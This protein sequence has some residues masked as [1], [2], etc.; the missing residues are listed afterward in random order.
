MKIPWIALLSL[1]L[2]GM[3]LAEGRTHLFLLS[4]Q[5]NMKNM[6]YT[7][8]FLPLV[9][10]AFPRDEVVIVKVAVGGVPISRW[11]P[12]AQGRLYQQLIAQTKEKLSGKKPDSITFIWMQGE[13]DHQ[14]DDTCQAYEKNLRTLYDQLKHD[15]ETDRINWV[16]GRLSDTAT[17][18]DPNYAQHKNWMKIR[19]TQERVADSIDRAVW[20]DRDKTNDP[21]NG[22]HNSP[23]GYQLQET[24]FAEA[25]IG[26]IRKFDFPGS[27]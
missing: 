4:G 24:L 1:M 20:V 14:N 22:V 5:S 6:E 3:V 21:E 18:M 27:K 25:A 17:R 12:A 23:E 7:N 26:L 10:A 11:V 13:R 16:I 19:A 8:R 15:L 2:P 9:Q